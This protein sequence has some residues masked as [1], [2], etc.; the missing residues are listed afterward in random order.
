[1]QFAF[2]FTVQDRKIFKETGSRDRFQKVEPKLTNPGIEKEHG[3]FFT[4][5]RGSFNFIN[6]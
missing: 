3:R 1:M 5:L 6:K 2:T 4:F